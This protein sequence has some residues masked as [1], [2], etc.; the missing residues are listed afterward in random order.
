MKGVIV[1]DDL[2]GANASGV[3]LKKIGLSVSSLFRLDGAA[4]HKADVLAYSTASRGLSSEEAF[5]RVREAFLQLKSGGEFFNK[6]IDSTLRGNIGAEIDG[7]LSALGDDF[8]AIVVPAYPDSGRIVANRTMLVNGMLL[9]ES[10]AGRDPKMPVA[11]DDVVD[12]VAQQTRHEVRY[13][14]L[15][16]LAQDIGPLAAAVSEAAKAARVLVF[17]AVRNEDVQK[18]AK[19]VLQSGCR[20]LTVDPGPLTMQFVYEMQVKEKREQKVLLVIGSVTATTKRQIADLLQKRRVFFVDMRVK[21]FFEKERREAEIRRVVN[22]ICDAVDAE[23][24]LLLTTTPLSDEGHLDLKATAKA[25][26]VTREDVSRILS[27]TLT[28]AAGEILEKSGKLEG[29]YCSGGDITIALLEKLDADGIEVRDEVLPLAVYG[30]ILGGRLPKL[31]IVTKGGMIGGDD[32]I[33]LC[34]EKIAKDIAL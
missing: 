5:R 11:S 6:R 1:A 16:D 17:D 32:A 33:G 27:G 19:A 26:G 4:A 13:F 15:K 12:L 18:I 22:K 25:L 20:V 31:R 24:V 28:E 30:R 7:A 3:L 29:I 21:E 23:D 34:L 8:T 10:D 14:S 9:T 2:T